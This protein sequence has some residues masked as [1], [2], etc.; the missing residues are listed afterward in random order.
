MTNA[1]V[2]CLVSAWKLLLLDH[3]GL[4]GEILSRQQCL[5]A[6]S[7]G[8]YLHSAFRLTNIATRF[9]HLCH[10]HP[11]A[12]HITVE[13]VPSD[14]THPFPWHPRRRLQAATTRFPAGHL[15]PHRGGGRSFSSSACMHVYMCIC[16]HMCIYIYIC[17]YRLVPGPGTTYDGVGGWGGMLTFMWT[18]RSS[19]C[20]A[21]AGWGGGGWGGMLTFMWTCRSSWLY[22]HAGWGG[23]GWGG[24]LTFMW[25]CRWWWY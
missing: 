16:T 22:A 8:F 6:S 4:W 20:Y 17:I 11:F 9:N 12:R 2:L 10:L 18:C 15:S 1:E 7:L 23:G 14:P 21:H 24:M 13:N 3:W 19:W 5:W 25:T